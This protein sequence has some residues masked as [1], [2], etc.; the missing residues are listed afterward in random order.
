MA[1]AFKNLWDPTSCTGKLCQLL[2]LVLNL[3][4]AV[5]H[6]A[7]HSPLAFAEICQSF[8]DDNHNLQV[9][10]NK[11]DILNYVMNH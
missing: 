3:C 11:S 4:P 5:F 8:P 7:L 9:G 10:L 6:S 2:I 1:P